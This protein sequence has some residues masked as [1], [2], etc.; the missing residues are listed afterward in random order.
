[1]ISQQEKVDI[2]KKAARIG[3]TV[4]RIAETKPGLVVVEFMDRSH[5]R[6]ALALRDLEKQFQPVS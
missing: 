6:R 3:L 4:L 2:I 5:K 1:M